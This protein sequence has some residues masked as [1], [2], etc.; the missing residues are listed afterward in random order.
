M[1]APDRLPDV[2]GEGQ[3]AR[4]NDSYVVDLASCALTPTP[5]VAAPH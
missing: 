3:S 2:S 5:D 4:V 1:H